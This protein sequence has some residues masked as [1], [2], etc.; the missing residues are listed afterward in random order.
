VLVS[1][2]PSTSEED[3][4]LRDLWQLYMRDL[5]DFRD[6]VVQVAGR[7]RD[8]RLRTYLAYDE[9]WPFLIRSKGEIAGFALVRKSKPATYVIGEFFIKPEFRHVGIGR[10]SASRILQKFRGNW[11]IPF[12][13]ENSRAAKFWRELIAELGYEA[14]ETK[15]QGD[16]W[17]S[18]SSAATE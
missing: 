17:L 6:S 7:Y 3:Q 12:Q 4:I 18:F 1:V 2:D 15:L 14:I 11:E 13:K 16:V 8:D 10:E 9:H 5:A